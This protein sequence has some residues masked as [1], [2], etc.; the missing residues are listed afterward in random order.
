MLSWELPVTP[1]LAMDGKYTM[2]YNKEDMR[3]DAVNFRTIPELLRHHATV[4]PNKPAYVFLSTD[5]ERKNIVTWNEVFEKSRRIAKSLVQLGIQA[6]EV[7]ALSYRSSPEWIFTNFGIVL[8]GARPIGLSFTYE[9]GSD[10]VAMMKC[11]EKCSAIFID[12]GQNDATW[13]IFRKLIDTFDETGNVRSAHMP[14]LRHVAALFKPEGVEDILTFDDLLT[15]SNEDTQ[16]PKVDIDDI[17]A[18]FQTSGS[19]GL[20]KVIAH[21]HRF[22]NY[23]G[24]YNQHLNSGPEEIMY[25]ARPFSYAGGCTDNLYQGETRVTLSGICAPPKNMTDW[26]LEVIPEERCTTTILLP[27]SIHELMQREVIQN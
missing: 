1:M 22:F 8:A 12:P 6:N 3:E 14:T 24:F 7:V 19:T 2:S 16:L 26:L 11:L 23:I 4:T 13:H 21:T 17:A 27:A 18:L 5:S 25:N 20:P 15:K 9:D 10:V